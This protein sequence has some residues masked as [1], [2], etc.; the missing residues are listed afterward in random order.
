M[1]QIRKMYTDLI[2][3]YQSHQCYQR[4]YGSGMYSFRRNY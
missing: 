1:T 3:A 2:C 4:F